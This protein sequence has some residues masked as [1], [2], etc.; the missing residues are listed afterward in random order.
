M[1]FHFP[2]MKYFFII[3]IACLHIPSAESGV[4]L[5]TG[6]QR[7]SGWGSPPHLV[8]LTDETKR[9]MSTKNEFPL[10]TGAT[11]ETDTS[12]SHGGF[13]GFS[14]RKNGKRGRMRP[15]GQ[16][17]SKTHGCSGIQARSCSCF[18]ECSGC[19]GLYTC[20]LTLGRCQLKGLSQQTE[21]FLQTLRD[22]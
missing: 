1:D 21:K 10:D 6:M 20:N 12:A 13:G 22:S 8:P 14:R 17:N 15:F 16:F 7:D 9:Q 11:Q 5:R 4:R 19:L 3:H 2:K 18:S